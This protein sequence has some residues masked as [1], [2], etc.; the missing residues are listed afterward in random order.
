MKVKVRMELNQ[1]L[2][3]NEVADDAELMDNFEELLQLPVCLT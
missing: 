1:L 3:T 2:R